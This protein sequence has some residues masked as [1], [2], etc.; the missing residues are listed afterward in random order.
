MKTD[1]IDNALVAQKNSILNLIMSARNRGVIATNVDERRNALREL[2]AIQW[3]IA[4]NQK[5][6]SELD[7]GYKTCELIDSLIE[8]IRTVQNLCH[9]NSKKL[10]NKCDSIVS[11]CYAIRSIAYR[12]HHERMANC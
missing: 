6:W 10:I 9:S 3:T 11:R 1:N 7:Y 8:A 4:I 5:L 12:E 2:L